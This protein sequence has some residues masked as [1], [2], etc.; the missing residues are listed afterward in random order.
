MP[1]VIRLT[2]SSAGFG[3][4]FTRRLEHAARINLKKIQFWEHIA[5]SGN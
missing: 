5:L 1:E 2:T 3:W 4:K